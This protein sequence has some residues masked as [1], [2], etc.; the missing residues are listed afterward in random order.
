MLPSRAQDWTDSQ[1]IEQFGIEQS[2]PGQDV[3]AKFNSAVIDLFRY[4]QTCGVSTQKRIFHHLLEELHDEWRE[5][6][7]QLDPETA[8]IA[9]EI[10]VTVWPVRAAD[11]YVRRTRRPRWLHV[12]P[13]SPDADYVDKHFRKWGAAVHQHDPFGP[14]PR[15]LRF[16][17]A[18]LVE[19]SGEMS[20]FIP[21]LDA[22]RRNGVSTLVI[23]PRGLPLEREY[24]GFS[25]PFASIETLRRVLEDFWLMATANMDL[26]ADTSDIDWG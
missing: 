11:M 7:A 19:V 23:K 10:M 16:Y 24:Q 18:A 25:V 9:R 22:L 2:D 4:A 21:I 15:S 3:K 1:I 5:R 12:A 6:L 26:D 14:A 8:D 13:P 20:P 17:D